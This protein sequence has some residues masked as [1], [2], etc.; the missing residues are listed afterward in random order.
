MTSV[1][2][3][4]FMFAA[5]LLVA[6]VGIITANIV[7]AVA[8][9]KYKSGAE[10]IVFWGVLFGLV[11]GRLAYVLSH[12][13]LYQ[14]QWAAAFDIRDGDLH[15]GVACV[16][17]ALY[18]VLRWYKNRRLAPALPTAVLSGVLVACVLHLVLQ[19]G[20]NLRGQSLADLPLQSAT[21]NGLHTTLASFQGQPV[22]LNL[23]ASWCGPCRREMPAFAQAQAMN[24][25]IAFIFLNQGESA[26][27]ANEFLTQQGLTLE[28]VY[29]DPQQQALARVGSA[30]LPTTLFIDAAGKVLDIRAGELSLPSLRGYL[31]RIRQP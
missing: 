15:V 22:V 16:V 9:R 1:Q 14:G 8:D 6:V 10:S 25:D 26:Q 11:A 28:H 13:S 31:E 17:A 29:L 12:L 2:V 20:D 7:A 5:G 30:G 4:P 21:A 24:P 19:S 18:Y 23:W 27:A 3:G